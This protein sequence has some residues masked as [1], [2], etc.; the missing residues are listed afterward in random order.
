MPTGIYST[1]SIW[2]MHM[3][4]DRNRLPRIP[5]LITSIQFPRL[6][7]SQIRL[8]WYVQSMHRTPITSYAGIQ[9]IHLVIHTHSISVVRSGDW[10]QLLARRTLLRSS[11]WLP[12]SCDIREDY[13]TWASF[14]FVIR[15]RLI[16]AQIF[17][18]SYFESFT[19]IINTLASYTFF[20]Q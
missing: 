17:Y 4:Q 18:V 20:T 11:R 7:S 3:S 13:T 1:H 14:Q 19:L 9:R 8:G 5:R 6:L 15:D 2:H 16:Q 12:R 10:A